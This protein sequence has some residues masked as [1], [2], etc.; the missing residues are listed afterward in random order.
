MKTKNYIL[1]SWLFC[2]SSLIYA[3]VDRGVAKDVGLLTDKGSGIKEG[4]TR[5]ISF[6]ASFN[7]TTLTNWFAG[8]DKQSI[9]MSSQLKAQTTY[10]KR[11]GLF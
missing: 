10:K 2:F 3:Q 6:N 9:G 8:G 7:Q 4:W 1:A 11:G 5:G